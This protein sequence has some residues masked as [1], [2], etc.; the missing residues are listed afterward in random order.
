VHADAL[1]ADELDA[2]AYLSFKERLA[3]G[4]LGRAF[5]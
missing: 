5:V 1:T 3:D 4:A 2:A